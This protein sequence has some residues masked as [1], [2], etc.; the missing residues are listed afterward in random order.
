ML[1]AIMIGLANELERGTGKTTEPSANGGNESQIWRAGNI[2]RKPRY[3]IDSPMGRG[4]LA[5]TDAD[6]SARE[7]MK[8]SAITKAILIALACPA[9][10][11]FT[12]CATQRPLSP[13]QQV[14][15]GFHELLPE[16]S[17]NFCDNVKTNFFTLRDRID[18]GVTDMQ[19][20][21]DHL[22]EEFDGYIHRA[23]R[24]KDG[25][26]VEDKLL[27][28]MDS[29]QVKIKQWLNEEFERFLIPAINDFY[30]SYTNDVADLESRLLV[31]T[32]LNDW[33]NDLRK[34]TVANAT[35]PQ[36]S[37]SPSDLKGGIT[38][39]TANDAAG[40]IPIAGDVYDLFCA[41]IYDPRMARIK[42]HAHEF[43]PKLRNQLHQ[44][45]LDELAQQLPSPV[46]VQVECQKQFS[47]KVAVATLAKERQ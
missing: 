11:F 16:A 5:G 23:R 24:S 25:V 10:F 33:L 30:D 42:N 19:P 17:T 37:L 26:M 34:Q 46:E 39:K 45:F 9:L 4:E 32:C 47:T 2:G 44:K 1:N 27:K 14:T 31:H 3:L 22:V 20:S 12:G 43:L 8:P 35:T 28:K 6:G 21:L 18:A 36:L 15:L 29:D 38:V 40:F 41:F 13:A 7:L